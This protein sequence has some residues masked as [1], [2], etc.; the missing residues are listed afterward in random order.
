MA[1]LD[2]NLERRYLALFLAYEAGGADPIAE[3]KR[4]LSAA[5]FPERR[6]RADA[7]LCLLV[8]YDQMIFRP[9]VGTI[10]LPYPL[11]IDPS[12]PPI[13][14]IRE[15]PLLSV[16]GDPDTFPTTMMESL[17]VILQQLDQDQY[18]HPAS[19]HDVLRAVDDVWEQLSTSFG[20]A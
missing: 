14:A 19:S 11:I 3:L 20:W 17:T 6:L 2:P 16:V 18:E 15:L 12:F 8:L 13:P 4:R 1:T 10:N 7:A 5:V 9:Y